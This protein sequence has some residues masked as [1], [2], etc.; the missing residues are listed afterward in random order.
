MPLFNSAPDDEILTDGSRPVNGVNNS[1][2]PSAIPATSA[3]DAENRLAQLDGLNRPRPGIIRLQ[4][5][6]P[7]GGLD[8]I[9][10]LGT[11]VFLANFGSNWYRY[12]NRGNVL[13]TLAGGPAYAPGSQVYSAIAQTAL[14]FSDGSDALLH[15]YSVLST[16]GTTNATINITAIPST[17]GMWVGQAISGAGIPA[18]ATIASIVSGTAITI[19]VAATASA[20]GVAL[21]VS[22]FG[23]VALPSAYPRALYPIWAAYRLIYAYQNTMVVSDALDPETFHIATGELTLDPILTDVITGQALW[24]NQAIAVFRNGSTWMVQTGPGLDVPD[25]SLDRVSA[26]VGCR[27]HGTIVQCGADVLFL[28]ESGRG[29]YALSQAPTS[30]QI[31]VWTPISVDIQKYINRINW[32]ACDNAR[33]TYWNDLYILSVPLDGSTF[34]NFCLVYSMSLQT[35]QG[36]WCFDIGS[37]DTAVRDFARD[38]TDPNH[39]ALLV[40]TKDG[41][42]SRFTYPVDLQYFDQNIDGT[43]QPYN[44][45]LRSRSFIFGINISEQYMSGININQLRPHSARFQFLESVDPVTVSVIADRTIELLKRTLDTSGYLLSLT[46]PGFPFDLDVEGYKNAVI[47]LLGTGLCN[48]LQFEFEGTGN[49]TLYQI[50]ASAFE[51]MPLLATQ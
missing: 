32:S 18:G 46:I 30:S 4:R 42:I 16:T 23:T 10:H 7:T 9:H 43:P 47:G 51:T 50:K 2:P 1:Q 8:S 28:S 17:T 35:W 33:A 12:D 26:T 14:Y 19:S 11:G 27:C 31:G 5:P 21:T 15:K 22:G 48:E 20:T 24:Q 6:S 40:A 44:S 3:E 41:I 39:T 34:N 29:V 38:R 37:V 49:W 25:W 13:A 45:L 36:L